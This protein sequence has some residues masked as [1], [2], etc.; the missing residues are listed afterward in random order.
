MEL[1]EDYLGHTPRD[2]AAR[3]TV[4]KV[5]ADVKWALWSLVQRCVSWLDFD[6]HEYGITDHPD[7]PAQLRSL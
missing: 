3:A 2:L 7:W 5:L 4:H 1:I 6:F